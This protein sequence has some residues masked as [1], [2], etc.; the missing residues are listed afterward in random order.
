MGNIRAA[1]MRAWGF[2]TR[3]GGSDDRD[4]RGELQFHAEMLESD[5]RR[6][7]MAAADARREARVRLGGATQVAESYADQRS[8]PA[9]ESFVQ[10][11]RYAVRTYRRAPG[12]TFAAL[13]TLALGIGAT[14]S[15]FS[16]VNAVLLRPLPYANPDRLVGISDAAT[17]SP[18]DVNQL[19]YGTFVDYRDRNRSFEQLVAIRSWQTTLVTTEAERLAGMRVSWNYFD[20]L[21]ARPALGRTFR[22]DEDHPDRY[23]VLVLSDGLW[24]RRFN[25]DPSVI[26]R[27]L[28]MNDQQFE[29]VGVMP[30]DFEDVVSSRF[31]K[32]AEL[33]AALGYDPALPYAC[34]SCQHLKAFGQLRPEVTPA[35]AAADLTAIRTD[36]RPAVAHRVRPERADQ[37][38]SA[39]GRH[40]GS[41]EGA[42]LCPP[43]CR[44]LRAP[45]R[46]RQRGQPAPRERHEP[47]PGDGGAR[48]TWGRARAAG[49][50]ARD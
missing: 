50:S 34:R 11:L 23:R 49:S 25:A 9:A 14:T 36:L 32:P 5:L 31:Y 27:I 33:W 6:G 20:M 29:V 1:L 26:G 44:R 19:G 24:R 30:A 47:V 4:L 22:K 42:T 10:D 43:G 45:D 16:V 35:Q 15:I 21:G 8:I 40:L 13:V 18:T 41:G 48:G 3:R 39:A 7:G 46:L 12:F 2:V 37:H 28:R 17:L 38:R